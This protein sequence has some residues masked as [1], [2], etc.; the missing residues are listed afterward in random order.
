LPVETEPFSSCS[1][2]R[3]ARVTILDSRRLIQSGRS[4][5][6]ETHLA[7]SGADDK[8]QLIQCLYHRNEEARPA[9]AR[10]LDEDSPRKAS[11]PSRYSGRGEGHLLHARGEDRVAQL[12]FGTTCRTAA[13]RRR[14]TARRRGGADRE[15]SLRDWLRH[16]VNNPHFGRFE[17]LE[18]ACMPGAQRQLGCHRLRQT[19]YSWQWGPARVAQFAFQG[20]FAASAT[21][22]T[23]GRISAMASCARFHSLIGATHSIRPRCGPGPQCPRRPRPAGPSSTNQ[24][25]LNSYRRETSMQGDRPGELLLER[26]DLR[27]IVRCVT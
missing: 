9:R 5:P 3:R 16:H 20:H 8:L 7:G 18:C 26:L 19:W 12:S 17:T 24:P 13:R 21:Q 23:T 2:T 6:L 15:T 14:E 4:L 27:W 25:V 1:S 11:G 10:Q 22:T